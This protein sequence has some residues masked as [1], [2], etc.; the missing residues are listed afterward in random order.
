[1]VQAAPRIDQYTIGY[2]L[3]SGGTAEVYSAVNEHG[4]QVAIKMFDHDNPEFSDELIE[5]YVEQE[6][7][8]TLLNH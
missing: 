5:K 2:H 4:Q 1:M 6:R 7:Q 3:G 8:V